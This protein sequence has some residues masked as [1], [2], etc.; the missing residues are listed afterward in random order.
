MKEQEN[1]A[2]QAKSRFKKLFEDC[3]AAL[4]VLSSTPRV[5]KL[6]WESNPRFTALAV[7]LSFITATLPIINLWIGKLLL[8]QISRSIANPNLSFSFSASF[9]SSPAATAIVPLL[10]G[11]AVSE[12]VQAILS[13]ALQYVE[14]RLSAE[15]NRTINEKIL[16]KANSFIDIGFFES[17]KFHDELQKAQN[18]AAHRPME[19]LHAFVGIMNSGFQFLISGI[20]FLLLQ[21]L[22]CLAVTS[23][24]IANMYLD[25]KN[26]RTFW[27][28][29]SW[30]IPEVRKM[31]Y[32]KSL[33]TD[34]RAVTEV[35]MFGLGDF[36]LQ[37]FLNIFKQ[38]QSEQQDLQKKHWLRA[39]VLGG[40][41]ALVDFTAYA[42][43]ALR[44]VSG[45]LTLGSF[46]FYS[47]VLGQL[48]SRLS[49]LIWF[50]SSLYEGNLF[51][52]DLFRFLE[53]EATMQAPDPIWALK[54]P[55]PIKQG[56]EFRNVGF[57]YPDSETDVLSN[58][59]FTLLPGQSV[60]LVGENGAGKTTIV[61]LLGRLY[62]PSDGEILVDGINLKELDIDSWRDEMAVIFQNYC[63]Y[64]M[65]A[66]ENIGIGQ[67]NFIDDE[68]RIEDA[69]KRSGAL[70]VIEKLPKKYDTVLGSYFGQDGD[71]SD[72]SEGQWQKLALARAFMRAPGATL[73]G[74]GSAQVLVLDEP[75]ASLDVQSE[76]EIY[77]RFQ[78]LT[79]D[80]TTLLISHRFSTVKMANL[81]LY[82][83]NGKIAEQGTHEELM[84]LN[85][86]YAKLYNMQADKYK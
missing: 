28:L 43:L 45:S 68:L 40:L 37:K 59:N 4:K 36:V 25:F 17:S 77:I 34:K 9:F 31:A 27:D 71:Q 5:L 53:M 15:L 86:A 2:G 78:E 54:A 18:E 58:L 67:I 16:R 55:K 39:S 60:A 85:G 75:T 11:L 73:S 21:P 51:I 61:K 66:R 84:N 14:S 7:S 52:N 74:N 41:S 64:Q 83:E 62:D 26:R 1:E 23:V 79:R 29:C 70:A 50:T 10:A 76:H 48:Q 22:I 12:L 63:H 44:T 49:S 30:K 3:K 38:F 32:Y 20:T 72:L 8:E 33:L 69:A 19:I 46:Y 56:I 35:R 82:L 24:S 81:I 13:P 42:F 6:I 47:G 80:K 65:T 57:K